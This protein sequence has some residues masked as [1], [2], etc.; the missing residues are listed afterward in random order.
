MPKKQIKALNKLAK[1]GIRGHKP[2]AIKVYNVSQEKR[3]RWS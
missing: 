3:R 1:R 2:S